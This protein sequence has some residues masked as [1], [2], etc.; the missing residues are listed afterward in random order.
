MPTVNGFAEGEWD[1]ELIEWYPLTRWRPMTDLRLL[2][3]GELKRVTTFVFADYS[4]D[5]FI[6]YAHLEP[7]GLDDCPIFVQWH[8]EPVLMAASWS[9]HIETYLRDP[10]HLVHF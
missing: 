1:D 7:E 9:E 4:L 2:P 6:Y 5:A 10:A 3:A 8:S